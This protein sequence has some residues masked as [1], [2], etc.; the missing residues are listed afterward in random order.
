MIKSIL[1]IGLLFF[2]VLTPAGAATK[3]PF[4]PGKIGNKTFQFSVEGGVA[5][6]ATTGSWTGT[7][8]T[9][10]ADRLVIRN[11]SGNT[12]SGSGLW[13]Y[14]GS[15]FKKSHSYT[16]TPFF[17]PNEPATITFWPEDSAFRYYIDGGD[18]KQWGIV[19][20]PEITV[21]QPAGSK[22]TSD[23]SRKN[24]GTV[25]KGQKSKPKVFKI[26]NLG[27]ADLT[28]LSINK[29]GAHAGS[30]DVGKPKKTTLKPK[31]ITTFEVVFKPTSKGPRQAE[32]QIFSN[33][34]DENP[35]TIKLSGTGAK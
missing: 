33:D 3:D 16:I 27:N 25:K 32:I 14:V 11:L 18:A 15:P 2:P 21:Q 19:A 22:L 26:K 6:L 12:V 23:K 8:L 29:K 4:A 30:F 13:K 5:P 10:P 24:F 1:A 35:F 7:F 9:Q 28:I 17:P 20:A 31:Q 34:L